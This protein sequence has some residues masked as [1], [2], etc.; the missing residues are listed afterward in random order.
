MKNEFP[1]KARA[2]GAVG[3]LVQSLMLTLSGAGEA[4]EPDGVR[5]SGWGP[6]CYTSNKLLCEEA[7]EGFLSS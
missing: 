1:R 3:S 7:R 6:R 2:R 4:G 5:R